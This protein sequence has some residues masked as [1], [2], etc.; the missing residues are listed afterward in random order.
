M[1][2]LNDIKG[3]KEIPITIAGKLMEVRKKYY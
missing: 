2:I 3:I 1:G